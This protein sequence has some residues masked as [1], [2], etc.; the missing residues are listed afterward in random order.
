VPEEFEPD[1]DDPDA[2]FSTAKQVL[3]SIKA[4]Y[5][6]SEVPLHVCTCKMID[7]VLSYRTHDKIRS[8]YI[9]SLLAG[10]SKVKT[11]AEESEAVSI[12]KDGRL[13]T[14]FRQILKTGRFASSPN[15]Q[16][17]P[18]NK[19]LDIRG[20]LIADP[21]KVFVKADW[22]AIEL[23]IAAYFSD[24]QVMKRLMIE[25][26]DM[27]AYTAALIWD[28]PY[29]QFLAEMKPDF[30][31]H[32]DEMSDQEKGHNMEAY[33]LAIKRKQQ[34]DDAKTTSF[35]VVYQGGARTLALN[36]TTSTGRT[37]TVKQCEFII[38]G[39]FKVYPELAKWL[40]DTNELISFK[41]YS[42]T[43]FGRR[44]V[45]GQN[46]SPDKLRMAVNFI[47]QGTAA[48]VL[49]QT[50]AR[51]DSAWK[52]ADI[53]VRTVL[54]IHDEILSMCNNNPEE[55]KYVYDAMDEAMTWKLGDIELTKEIQVVNSLSKL[56]KSLM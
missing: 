37:Y 9:D 22:N 39:F 36:L 23:R 25:G 47:I 11:S 32:W 41:G 50:L 45:V 27:H 40:Q 30:L 8:T 20:L 46:P 15:L 19:Q 18:K 7:H 29:E 38:Q 42:E 1:F 33:Q 16:N 5:F 14:Q 21:N 51:L 24:D 56:E 10:K 35:L 53:D 6:D 44:I 13:H 4:R 31:E 3:N 55:Y 28:V 17:L 12:I 54:H 52:H 26:K 43:E 34:R 49:K 48:D 2:E